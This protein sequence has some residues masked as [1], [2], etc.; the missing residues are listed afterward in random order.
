MTTHVLEAYR[1]DFESRSKQYA[2]HLYSVG[3]FATLAPHI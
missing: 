3:S 1:I 2:E